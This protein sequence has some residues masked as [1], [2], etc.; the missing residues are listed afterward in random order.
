MCK[1]SPERQWLEMPEHQ[2]EKIREDVGFPLQDYNGFQTFLD[3]S[4]LF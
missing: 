1:Y 2:G 3:N 4:V